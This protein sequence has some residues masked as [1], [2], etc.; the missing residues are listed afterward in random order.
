MVMAQITFVSQ[1]LP[2]ADVPLTFVRDAI[3]NISVF[4]GSFY[5][6]ACLGYGTRLF[7]QTLV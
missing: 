5:V 4:N 2:S 1:A 6:S 7:D 3:K